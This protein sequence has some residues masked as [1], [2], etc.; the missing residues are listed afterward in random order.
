MSC[1]QK[2]QKCQLP[3]KCPPKCPP[4]APDPCPAPSPAPCPPPPPSCCIPRCCI[5]G[6]GDC[7][8]LLSHGFPGVCLGQPQPST[9]CERE[10]SGCC[11]CCHGLGG[12][13]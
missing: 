6:F 13:R 1:Q 5:S 11:H 10:S 7:C 4:Q 9:C 12:C 2:Q 3:A 8:S